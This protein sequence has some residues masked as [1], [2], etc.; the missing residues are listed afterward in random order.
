MSEREAKWYKS[1]AVIGLVLTL[2]GFGLFTLVFKLI[3]DSVV[4]Q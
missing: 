2:A 3:G 1:P 4:G